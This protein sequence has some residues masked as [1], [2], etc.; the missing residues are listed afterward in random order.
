MDVHCTHTFRQF[1][2]A[3]CRVAKLKQANKPIKAVFLCAIFSSSSENNN[4]ISFSCCVTFPLPFSCVEE[5]ER[6]RERKKRESIKM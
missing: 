4:E 2:N 1:L 5:S 3:L 6:E